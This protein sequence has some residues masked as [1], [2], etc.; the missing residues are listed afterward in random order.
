MA[1]WDWIDDRTGVSKTVWPLMT[2]LVP[3][4]AKWWYV[5]G[6]ATLCAFIVQIVSGVAL[7]FSYIP[8]SDEAFT[9]LKYISEVAPLGNFLRGMHYWG[10][11][12]MVLMV[13]IHMLQVFLSGAF[14]F[15]REA[16]WLSGLFLFALV[17]GM[18]FT[19]Q[20]LRWDQN[21][22]WSVML[23]AEAAGRIPFIGDLLA[24]II[25]GGETIGGATLNR[26]YVVHVF[27][28]PGLMISLIVM[29][30]Y[31]VLRHG[32]AEP[33][34]KGK[35]V[36]PKT[37]RKE[38]EDEL[39][40]TGV[41]FFPDAAW[42]DIVFALGVIL[43]I[44]SAA[45]FIGP[46]A[47]GGAP[48]PSVIDAQPRPDWYFLWLFA[49]MALMPD[50]LENLA[51]IFGPVIIGSIL[52]LLPFLFGTGE[53]HPARRPW[54][55]TI[56]ILTIISIIALWIAGAKADWSPDFKAQPLTAE[57]VGTTTG[58]VATG[59]TLFYEKSCLRCHLIEGHGGRRG[60]D[61]T[62]VGD[63]L[64]KDQM[65]IRIMNGGHNMPSF[66]GILKPNELESIVAFLQSRA[67][68]VGPKNQ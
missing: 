39:K 51:I 14:K 9:S 52:V 7:A 55:V 63:R 24:R 22:V 6:S 18:A 26:F 3:R 29:H 25:L 20:L 66:A 13:G 16:T 61:L 5:F 12:M 50:G 34:V 44:A 38:Y 37:Y 56:V 60:P 30:L 17:L 33:P 11:G 53:R 65:I 62:Y 46:P 21:A 32:I 58:P 48:D 47:I 57:I 41:P 68:K 64:T 54:A 27:I 10:A 67:R 43:V 45:L 19:G 59:A 35:P 40:K 36:D 2:H 4:G 31:L 15:P 23:A 8:S 42:R 1:A 28:I 49:I